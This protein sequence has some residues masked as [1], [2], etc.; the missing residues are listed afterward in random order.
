MRVFLYLASALNVS[1][2]PAVNLLVTG[3]VMFSIFMLKA[4]LH[5]SI[6]RKLPIEFLEVT[7]YANIIFL[8]FAN[9][10]TLETKKHQTVVAYISGSITVALFL[11]VLVYH[12][13][14][15]ILICSKITPFIMK[16]KL[17]N[18][19]RKT[20]NSEDGVSLFN[21]RQ[22]EGDALQ[23]TV[24]WVDAPTREQYDCMSNHL[25][26]QTEK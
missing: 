25:Q 7:C 23:P 12:I 3:V 11:V 10:Y 2:T 21:Y 20:S 18:K 6:Y 9:F 26:N 4:A 8:S 16:L 17:K 14:T 13:F 1:G 24:S 19:R 5:G 22:V 15:E